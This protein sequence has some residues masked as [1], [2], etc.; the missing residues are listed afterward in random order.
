MRPSARRGFP[1]GPSEPRN[2]TQAV[3][4]GSLGVAQNTVSDWLIKNRGHNIGTDNVSQDD[5]RVKIDPKAKPLILLRNLSQK[6]SVPLTTIKVGQ[7]FHT[8][9]SP[10]FTE[11]LPLFCF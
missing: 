3:I 11:F 10:A 6:L 9:F 2:K 4:A 5:V 8:F 7:D 1:P